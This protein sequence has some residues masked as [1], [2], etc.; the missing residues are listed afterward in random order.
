MIFPIAFRLG[1]FDE[2]GWIVNPTLLEASF[3]AWTQ[4]ELNYSIVSATVPSFQSF[5]K[6]LNTQF[7]GIGAD[8][9]VY[10][11]GSMSGGLEHQSN[12]ASFQMSKLRSISRSRIEQEEEDFD[13]DVTKP[14]GDV[15]HENDGAASNGSA[16]T[17]SDR[18]ESG[19]GGDTT[20]IASDESQRL[21][22]RKDITW[23]IVSENR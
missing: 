3:I 17:V 11:T 19:A 4:C 2:A 6:N 7:G 21:M 15:D 10:G 9:S 13:M 22:I 1:A 18:K 5:L 14:G 12:S 23:H 8:D 16:A 20:S